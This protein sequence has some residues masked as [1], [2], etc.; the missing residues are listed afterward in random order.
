MVNIFQCHYQ[1]QNFSSVNDKLV[2]RLLSVD[3]GSKFVTK[4]SRKGCEANLQ[5][6]KCYVARS[7]GAI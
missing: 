5:S 7:V 1:V 6:G 4:K 2:L 3:A